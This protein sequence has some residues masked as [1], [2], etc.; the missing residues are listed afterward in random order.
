M[1]L[2][3]V[4]KPNSD[5]S[6]FFLECR[7]RSF[8]G[9]GFG[10]GF[11]WNWIIISVLIL[12]FIWFPGHL[13]SRIDPTFPCAESIKEPN[14]LKLSDPEQYENSIWIAAGSGQRGLEPVT[15]AYI[16]LTMKNKYT[17]IKLLIWCSETKI[18]FFFFLM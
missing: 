8:L 14:S 1:E 15:R 18:H 7:S 6:R 9:V 17:P 11:V 13:M 4:L 16:C 2:D 10:S 5:R 12:L 3:Q